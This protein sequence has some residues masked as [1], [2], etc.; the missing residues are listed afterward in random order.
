VNA[1]VDM[2]D[3]PEPDTVHV[4]VQVDPSSIVIE[5]QGDRWEGKFDL[6]IAQ[7]DDAGKMVGKN[8]MNR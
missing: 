5:K 4:F 2:V 8:I 1:R 6:M 3:K 7:K